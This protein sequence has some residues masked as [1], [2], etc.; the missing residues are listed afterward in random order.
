M[1]T[2]EWFLKQFPDFP[3]TVEQVAWAKFLE[4]QGFVFLVEFGFENAEIIADQV[5]DF[6]NMTIQ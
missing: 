5:F 2:V 3:A 1:S 6:Q 4:Q